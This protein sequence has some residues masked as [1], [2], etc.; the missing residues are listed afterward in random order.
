[1]APTNIERFNKIVIWVL[2]ECYG[3]FPIPVDLEIGDLEPQANSEYR[4][5]FYHTLQHLK[6]EG[7]LDFRMIDAMATVAIGAQ[8]TGRG[9]ELLKSVPSTLIPKRSFGDHIKTASK[10]AAKDA[11]GALVSEVFKAL[12]SG[13][14]PF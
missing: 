7:L 12:A 9:L 10:G 11:T 4:L 3:S 5:A 14:I 13:A 1:M 8:L 6:R 2:A